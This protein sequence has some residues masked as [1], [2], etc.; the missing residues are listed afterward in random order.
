MREPPACSPNRFFHCPQGDKPLPDYQ[1][2]CLAGRTT[3]GA[4]AGC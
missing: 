3:G 2:G 4:I 1:P